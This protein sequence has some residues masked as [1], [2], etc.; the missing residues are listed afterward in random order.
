M[1]RAVRLLVAAPIVATLAWSILVAIDSAHADA[2]V[3]EAATEMRTWAAT[4]AAPQEGTWTSVQAMLKEA[5]QV[6]PD[7]PT[8]TELLGLL[9]MMRADDPHAIS[10]SVD[11]LVKALHD[12]PVSAFTWA[13]LAEARYRAGEPGRNLELALTRAVHLGP[14]EPAVQ[15]LVADYGLA[16]WN[17]VTPATQDAIDRMVA[18]GMRRNP[19]EMLQI[20]GRRGRLDSA[21]RHLADSSRKAGPQVNQLCPSWELTP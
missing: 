20:S 9:G 11:S 2:L 6:R 14:A 13:N 8:P 10:D 1:Q 12:R 5:S 15:R 18:A 17:E 3:R 21:C 7:D 4:R 16:V 19:L